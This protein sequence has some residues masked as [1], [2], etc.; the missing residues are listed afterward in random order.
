[1]SRHKNYRNT[2]RRRQFIHVVTKNGLRW[3][4]GLETMLREE[5][6]EQL[7]F[8]DEDTGLFPFMLAAACA[9]NNLNTVYQMIVSDPILLE[10][11]RCQSLKQHAM[12]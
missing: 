9:N 11:V 8:Q 12:A 10:R 4:E 6:Y 7:E 3:E 2:L 5:Y 1:M